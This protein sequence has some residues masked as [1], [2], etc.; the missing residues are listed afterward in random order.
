MSQGF[1]PEKLYII[2]P[3]VHPITAL[4]PFLLTP[5]KMIK[6]TQLRVGT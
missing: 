2:L 1:S 6:T 3:V 5:T 4:E